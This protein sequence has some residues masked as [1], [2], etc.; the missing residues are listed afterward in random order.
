MMAYRM[1]YTCTF[2]NRTAVFLL[3]FLYSL[4]FSVVSAQS[5]KGVDFSTDIAMFVPSAVGG[6]ISLIE[7][8]K[9]GLVQLVGSGAASV[10][11]AYALKYTVK[12]ERPDG[13]DSHSFPSNHA[14]VA[15]MGATFIQQRY[16]WK[17]ALPAYAISGYVAWGRVYADRH[18]VWD[19]IAGAAIGAG[20]AIAITT[21]F[22]KEHRVALCPVASPG[23]VGVS[24]VIGL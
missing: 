22:V 9:K 11:A 6:F 17:Y 18:D 24:A 23:A 13:S 2:M 15:F 12:K 5:R 1:F 3:L 10:A 14:G 7:G 20:C 4:S 19:V 8:D 16:G 21:P